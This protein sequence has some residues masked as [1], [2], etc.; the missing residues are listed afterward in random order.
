[1]HWPYE[2]EAII[3]SLPRSGVFL[4]ARV[5]GVD[6]GTVRVGL[7]VS[8]PAGI[9]AQPL[10][11]IDGPG[12]AGFVG[13]VAERARDLDVEEIVVGIPLRMDGGRGPAAAAAE[14][15]ARSLE[16]A[17]GLPVRRWDERLSTKQAQ[18]AMRAGGANG[19]KQRGTVD[20]VAAALVLGAYLEAK[21]A[22]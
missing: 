14:E 15:F 5:L 8:D 17:S 19:R 21:R 9:T 16:E 20:M 7:A 6:V 11:V 12:P 10:E 18:R 2:R 4:T 1:M 13:A 22:R 3:G